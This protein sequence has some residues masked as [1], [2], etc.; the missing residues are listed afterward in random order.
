M[1]AVVLVTGAS[2]GIGLATARAFAERGDRVY[3]SVRDGRGRE[4]VQ[5]AAVAAGAPI[6]AVTLDVTDD[7]SIAAAVDGI[8]SAAGRIDVL[9]NNAGISHVGAVE[10]APDDVWRRL[11]EVNVLGPV[12]MVRAV[13]PSMRAAGAG[14]IVN[15]SSANGRAPA[16]FG[17]PYSA[18]KAALD[19]VSEVLL[20][21]LEP[22]GIR[23]AVVAPGQFDTA[24]FGKLQADLTASLDPGSPYAEREAKLL[25]ASLPG[26][27]GTTAGDPALAA[28][29]IVGVATGERPGFRH[30]AGADA[31]RIL[32]ARSAATDDEWVDLVRSFLRS[33]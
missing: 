13:L 27:G 23:V 12:R 17:A 6:Q 19:A 20:H 10:T 1:S 22:F 30:A 5:G 32:G 3:A 18:S 7:A 16:A 26:A 15:V 2:S 25:E 8:V 29:V 31:E 24:I 21:E 33:T 14:T 11:F 4:A 28:A 9:V